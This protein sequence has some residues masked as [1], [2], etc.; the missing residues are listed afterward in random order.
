MFGYISKL[1]K[2]AIYFLAYLPKVDAQFLRYILT[3][4]KR[5]LPHLSH[6]RVS[7]RRKIL[8]QLYLQI[9]H[10][11]KPVNHKNFGWQKRKNKNILCR[12]SRNNTRQSFLC[13]VS[14]G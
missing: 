14:A 10:T 3:M 5:I 7:S 11:S 2:I 6:R 13:R 8:S 9:K 4:S 12:V 1:S